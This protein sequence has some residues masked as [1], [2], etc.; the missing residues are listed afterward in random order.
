MS[1]ADCG[2]VIRDAL[3][4]PVRPAGA[5]PTRGCMRPLLVVLTMVLSTVWAG[6]PALPRISPDAAE[7]RGLATKFAQQPD[8]LADFEERRQFPFRREPVLLKG[9]VRVSRQHGLSLSYTA[10]EP[11]VVIVDAKGVLV[12]ETAGQ[13]PAPDDP[14]ARAA[15]DAMFHILRLD[16]SALEKAFELSGAHGADEWLLTLVPRDEAVRRAIGDIHVAGD[17][18]SVRRIELRRSARQH[19]EVVIARPRERK[20][21]SVEDVKRY[22]R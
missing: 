10:P 8:A 18:V 5:V 13:K 11:R 1:I 20:A 7:W 12:R 4:G 2:R 22:F 19:I 14:R 9:E 15:N 17:D 21:F 6:Q 16:F 3:P